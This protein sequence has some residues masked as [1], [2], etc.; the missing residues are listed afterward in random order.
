M[1]VTSSAKQVEIPEQHAEGS[2]YDAENSIGDLENCY[3]S[4]IRHQLSNGE[5]VPQIIPQQQM[6]DHQHGLPIVSC[7][8]MT[9][10]QHHMATGYVISQD[11]PN[12]F[13]LR[14]FCQ[15]QYVPCVLFNLH[16]VLDL[17][18]Q[19]RRYLKLQLT[20][21]IRLHFYMLLPIWW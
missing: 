1:Q 21:P 19:P 15:P 11:E 14:I 18:R 6:F 17:L 3:S 16:S 8:A 5:L 20:L 12:F 4:Q 9:D 7:S 2:V 10:Y 13:S